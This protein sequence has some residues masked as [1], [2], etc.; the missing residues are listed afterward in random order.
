MSHSFAGRF[1]LIALLAAL[2]ACGGKPSGGQSSTQSTA[3]SPRDSSNPLIGAW[4]INQGDEHCPPGPASDLIFATRSLTHTYDG[5]TS[6]IDVSYN[7]S[8]E[9]VW[10]MTDTGVSGAVAYDILGLGKM[11]V[12]SVYPCVYDRMN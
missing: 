3:A 6:T 12:E 2:T 1:A 9:K 4:R 5:A 10:V 11:R 8:P 7:V